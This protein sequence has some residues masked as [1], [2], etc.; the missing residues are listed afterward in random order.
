MSCKPRSPNSLH[1]SSNTRPL[2]GS[3]VDTK[4]TLLPLEIQP[5]LGS[6]SRNSARSRRLTRRPKVADGAKGG[7]AE[8]TVV[9]PERHKAEATA[10]SNR[11]LRA[12]EPKG[13]RK[14][15]NTKKPVRRNQRYKVIDEALQEIA[16]SRPSTQEEVFQSIEGR[17]VVIPLA[18]PFM[19]AHGWIP[20]FRR[21]KAAA[22]AWLSKRWAELNLSPLPRGPKN[23]KK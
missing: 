21:D 13:P 3:R 23:P 9:Q 2:L 16:E 22:R 8:G 18:E 14:G 5:S 20:G 6:R 19:A 1:L 10:D 7:P 11:K 17:H 12:Q 4:W 15:R